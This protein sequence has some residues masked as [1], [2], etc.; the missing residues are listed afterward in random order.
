MLRIEIPINPE[1]WDEKRQEFVKPKT[2]ILQLE[3]C[4]VSL[5]KWESKWCKPF[6]SNEEKSY[7]EVLDYIKCMTITQNVDPEVYNHLTESN[8]TDINNYINAPMT[9]TTFTNDKGHGNNREIITSE[10]VYYWMIALN[11]PVEFQKWHINRL[12]TLIRVCEIKNSP[13]KKM[14]KNEIMSRNAALNEAR[15]KKLNSRG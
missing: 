15:R 10:L 14:S 7:E 9:A 12:L 5:S 13:Q 2:Q 1:G 11:I 4:L 6:F 8:I 3:H